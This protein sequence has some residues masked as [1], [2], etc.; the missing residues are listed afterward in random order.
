MRAFCW[1]P[2]ARPGSK[3]ERREGSTWAV[4]SSQPT[5]R[6]RDGKRLLEALVRRRRGAARRGPGVATTARRD[7]A[8]D[9]AVVE[10]FEWSTEAI[11]AAHG[12]RAVRRMWDDARS[13]RLR[14]PPRDD[15]GAQ[16]V[17]RVRR[18]RGRGVRP[19]VAV[20]RPSTP[21]AVSALWEEVGAEG[22]MRG[23]HEVIIRKREICCC[24]GAAATAMRS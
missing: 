2:G 16:P 11:A 22:R 1:S 17:R 13:L 6:S 24:R 15:R 3:V 14:P 18:H 8:G 9:G 21:L 20:G 12:N 10:V 4:S 23:S 5:G 7:R 19:I